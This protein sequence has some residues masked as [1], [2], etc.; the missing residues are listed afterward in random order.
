ME[1]NKKNII[2]II[3]TIII[4]V[5]GG[6]A[7]YTKENDYSSIE[8]IQNVE[9]KNIQEEKPQDNTNNSNTNDDN[10]KEESVETI[11]VHITGAVKKKGILYLK[12]GSRVA[13]AIK[14]AGGATKDAQLDKINLAYIL[15]DGQK[16]HIPSKNE[17]DDNNT[18]IIT[19]SGD[20]I[21]TE[22]NSKTNVRGEN[23][24]V[25]INSANQ[26]ELETLPGIG[27]SLARKNS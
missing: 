16:I 23:T 20:N 13:D 5:I 25:N 2:I 10:I 11:A 7:M 4:L 17:K 19:G 12:E 6:V 8:E 18:Y 26:T 14:K 9:E 22:E 27:S 1:I 15:E 21:S 24:K 3:I